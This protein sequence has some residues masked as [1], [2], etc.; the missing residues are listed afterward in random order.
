MDFSKTV[1][2]F[3]D[4]E[5]DG[6]SPAVNSCRMMGFVA[7]VEPLNI[8]SFDIKQYEQ[9]IVS[10]LE[11]CIE[12][13]PNKTPDKQCMN[14]FWSKNKKLL[15]YI[16]VK[17]VDVKVAME[18]FSEWYNKLKSSYKKIKFC[19]HPTSYDHMWLNSLYYQYGPGIK[20]VLPYDAICSDTIK[21]L[22]EKD[23]KI[24]F[25]D[26]KHTSLPHTHNAV[27]D[28]EQQGY[29]YFQMLKQIKKRHNMIR[30]SVWFN[31]GL[32][33]LLSGLLLRTKLI[34]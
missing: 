28:A 23:L 8:E 21:D 5:N 34:H 17:S 2:I 31:I 30:Y 33:T 24:K 27:D 12:S 32:V 19:A 29:Q 6:P 7:V 22:Y 18:I 25:K 26:L 15:D 9:L 11:L 3:Y 16:N 20:S 10:R 1:Y 4:T 13:Q 14:E